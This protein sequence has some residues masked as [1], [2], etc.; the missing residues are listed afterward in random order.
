MPSCPCRIACAQCIDDY[1]L[2]GSKCQ[3]GEDKLD[4]VCGVCAGL[5]VVMFGSES[6]FL[7][8]KFSCRSLKRVVV[9][10]GDVSPRAEPTNDVEVSHG[11]VSR[12]KV[13]HAKVCHSEGV[14]VGSGDVSPR[15]ELTVDV[16]VSLTEVSLVASLGPSMVAVLYQTLTHRLWNRQ[17][18]RFRLNA[19]R[20]LMTVWITVSDGLS[21]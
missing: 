11:E 3:I 5:I 20:P 13:H 12:A 17:L 16:D 9:G 19:Y 14:A 18:L 21:R 1:A 7:S 8:A 6:M 15:A 10:S 4:Q 2:V